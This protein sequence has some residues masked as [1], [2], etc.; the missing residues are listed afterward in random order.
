MQSTTYWTDN[1]IV[2]H[3]LKNEKRRFQTF[4]ANRDEEIR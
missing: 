3:Y 4:V 2:L 1:E